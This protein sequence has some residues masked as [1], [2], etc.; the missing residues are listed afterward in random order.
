MMIIMGAY[1]TDAVNP[2]AGR[3]AYVSSVKAIHPTSIGIIDPVSIQPVLP[4]A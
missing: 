1:F 3:I 4:A 2:A